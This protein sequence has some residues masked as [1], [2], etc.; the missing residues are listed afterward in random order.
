MAEILVVTTWL[1]IEI[2][3]GRMAV[4]SIQGRPVMRVMRNVLVGL[5]ICCA[6]TTA[7]EALSPARV[8]AKIPLSEVIALAKPYPNLLLQIRLELVRANT[9]RDK[10]TCTSDKLDGAWLKLNAAHVGPYQCQIGKRKLAVSTTPV[11]Y[12]ARGYKLSPRAADVT[13]NA[14]RIQETKL[15]WTWS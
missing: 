9:T 2:G 14:A 8:P 11:F 13:A 3:L 1:K 7:S 6:G 15:K 4:S 10:V 5:A 12:D